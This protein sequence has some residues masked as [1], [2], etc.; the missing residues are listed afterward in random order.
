MKNTTTESTASQSK[1]ILL[2]LEKGQKLTQLQALKLFQCL[3]LGA[4]IHELRQ[5]GY[6]IVSERHKDTRTG[7]QYAKYTLVRCA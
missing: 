4:R 3:R 7:K 2:H 5:L 1:R 6:K